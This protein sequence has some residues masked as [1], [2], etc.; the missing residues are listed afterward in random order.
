MTTLSTLLDRGNIAW[1]Y[2]VELNV[3]KLA[4]G[5]IV[6]LYFSNRPVYF[7]DKQF[8]PAVSSLSDLDRAANDTMSPAYLP[9]YG[10]L[11]IFISGTYKPDA[12]NSKEWNLLL[13]KDTYTM[14]GQGVVIKIGLETDPYANFTTVFEGKVGEVTWT[15]LELTLTLY[16]KAK[17]LEA[18]IPDYELPESEHVIEDSWEQ[19]VPLII[20]EVKN[21][22][23]TLIN[24]GI[25][26]AYPCKYALACHAIDSLVT[27]YFNQ[28]VATSPA[29]YLFTQ[30]DISPPKKDSALGGSALMDAFGPYSGLLF[31]AN[32]LIRVDSITIPNS[33]GS[34]GPGIGLATF[35]WSMD[36]GL[37]W[38]AE[39]E[40]TWKLG[41]D[42]TTLVEY[43]TAGGTMVVTGDYTG[44]WKRTY[45]VKVTLGGTVGVVVYPQ[46][47][48]SEDDGATWSSPI[49]IPN[50]SPIY[51]NR[52]LSVAFT[53][54]LAL[55]GVWTWTFTEI[56]IPLADG[57][58]IQFYPQDG[59]NFFVGDEWSFI[60]M[61]TI[62]ISF[63]DSTDLTIDAKGLVSPVTG[64]FA[65]TI[66]E[67]IR[68][69]IVQFTDWSSAV[70]DTASF[71]A[72]DIA[73]PYSA[74]LVVDS[75]DSIT[76]IIDKL[77]TGI[78]AIYSITVAGQFYLQ[79]LI[80]PTGPATLEL[81]DTQIMDLPGFS[82]IPDITKRVILQYDTNYTTNSSEIAGVSQERIAWLKLG[83]RQVSRR[84][85]SV[86]VNYPLA[87]DM[88]PLETVINTRANAILLADKLL[89]LYKVPHETIEIVIKLQGV[90]LN[91][92][93]CVKV[94]RTSFAQSGQFY[95]VQGVSINFTDGE[96]TLT[97]WR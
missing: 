58:S 46:F 87:A 39:N 63:S 53:G 97:L 78:P 42:P 91:I 35:K 95:I 40:L 57:V 20:G 6:P 81:T 67:M 54:A 16:D 76:S 65:G 93:N 32:W 52:G 82:Q 5:S 26:G 45:K 50:A 18:N 31:K 11:T 73:I 22:T 61:S 80:V 86:K 17:D 44:D 51:L 10:D 3:R 88:D 15:D 25:A 94:T 89:S 77:L 43:P 56:P 41:F 84:D 55:N 59:Q 37:T 83:Y 1:V 38:Q 8:L 27:V 12:D 29:Q 49:D 75:Q 48:W 36:N 9:T 13:Y 60:L 90:L 21:Y 72:F 30:M 2:L 79:E 68:A 23:P 66:G 19:T 71:T 85:E 74:G 64:L 7:A 70:F 28:I 69:M 4:D 92:G 24:S 14:Q 96:S 33:Q 47:T 62:S 34:F